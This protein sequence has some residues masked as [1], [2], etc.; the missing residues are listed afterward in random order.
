M[1]DE[2]NLSR[3]LLVAFSNLLCDSA[4]SFERSSNSLFVFVLRFYGAALFVLG[5]CGFFC[6]R[7][8]FDGLS[9]CV[10]ELGPGWSSWADGPGLESAAGFF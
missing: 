6:S 10:L 1:R 8:V 5:G 4:A 2:I 3:C 9:H 7:G